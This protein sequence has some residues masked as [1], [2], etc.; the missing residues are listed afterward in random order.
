MA[1]CSSKFTCRIC[2]SCLRRHINDNVTCM[3]ASLLCSPNLILEILPQCSYWRENH[4]ACLNSKPR[5]QY[6]N[7]SLVPITFT[8]IV[9]LND[10]LSVLCSL[11]FFF[12]FYFFLGWSFCSLYMLLVCTLG[13]LAFKPWTYSCLC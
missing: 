13:T 9:V 10:R 5:D 1:I 8:E 3:C 4:D 6:T 7:S 2:R 11:F 12:L